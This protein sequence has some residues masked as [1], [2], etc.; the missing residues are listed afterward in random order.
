MSK[1]KMTKNGKVK[2]VTQ[3]AFDNYFKNAGWEISD[4]I[5]AKA[6]EAESENVVE[7]EN[8]VEQETI[9]DD[10]IEN[11]IED[12]WN[13][14]EEDEAVEKPISEMDREELKAFAESH[15]IDIEGLTKI[16]QIREAIKNNI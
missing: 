13:D 16:S 7:H 2:E 1:V 5:S 4:N 15:N 6:V 14:V 11:T 3:S 12:E 8:V 9:V 10:V